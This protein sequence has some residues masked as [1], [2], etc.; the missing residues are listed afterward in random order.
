MDNQFLSTING[1]TNVNNYRLLLLEHSRFQSTASL[2]NLLSSNS[3][4]FHHSSAIFHCQTPK[5][6]NF[7]S[8]NHLPKET[9]HLSNHCHV[10]THLPNNFPTTKSCSQPSTKHSHPPPL[11]HCSVAL[12]RSNRSCQ[13][14]RA[15]GQSSRAPR[16][17]ENRGKEHLQLMIHAA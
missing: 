6:S 9:H 10:P 1:S 12:A 7:A 4:T 13:R 2:L 8:T 14:T 5:I 15:P 16:R 17:R 11:G 3:A